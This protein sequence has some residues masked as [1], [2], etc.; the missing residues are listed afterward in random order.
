MYYTRFRHTQNKISLCIPSSSLIVTVVNEE[1]NGRNIG[2]EGVT[3][4]RLTVNS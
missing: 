2:P 3:L 1:D 4:E